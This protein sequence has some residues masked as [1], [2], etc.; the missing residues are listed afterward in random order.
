MSSRPPDFQGAAPVVV[1][2][3][4]AVFDVPGGGTHGEGVGVVDDGR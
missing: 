1:A 3:R 4:E 2:D